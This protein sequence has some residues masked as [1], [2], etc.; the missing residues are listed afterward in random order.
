M[1]NTYTLIEA[2]TLGS[3]AAV[4][5]FTS[6]PNTYTDL[7]FLCSVKST[8]IGNDAENFYIKFNGSSSSFSA[9]SLGGDGSSAFSFTG[10]NYAGVVDGDTSASTNTF[11]NLAIYIPNYA[12]SNNKSYSVDSVSEANATL[13]YALL[14]AGLW[15][16]SA[17][18]TSVDFNVEF[19]TIAANSTFYLYGIKNS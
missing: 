13:V 10:T 3:A 6:I 1:A 17:A 16:S 8:R 9:R 7:Q 12:G 2:K 4:V 18:I 11:A 15:S 14:T 19:T 5:S